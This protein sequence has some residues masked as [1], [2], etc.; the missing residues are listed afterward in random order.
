MTFNIPAAI[1]DNSIWAIIVGVGFL[2]Q[3]YVN[4]N[5][6]QADE[7]EKDK[8]DILHAIELGRI[9]D[10]IYD[11]EDQI[12]MLQIYMEESPASDL[13]RARERRKRELEVKLKRLEREYTEEAEG[14]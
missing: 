7:L 5:Y 10:Q 1:R 4:T 11:T 2:F 3:F 13:N 8:Y 12:L 9:Q 14:L 6:V